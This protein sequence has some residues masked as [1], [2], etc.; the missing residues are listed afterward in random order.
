MI[1]EGCAKYLPVTPGRRGHVNRG[2]GLI[3]AV[4]L[5]SAQP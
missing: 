2:F 4:F 1:H 3:C 5:L